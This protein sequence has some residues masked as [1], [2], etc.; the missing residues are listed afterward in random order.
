MR[1]CKS[2]SELKNK[3]RIEVSARKVIMNCTVLDGCAIL[4]LVSWP[5]SSDT[6][7]A[8]VM[9]YLNSFC[10]LIQ[11][12]LSTGD[13]YLVFDRYITFSTKGSYRKARGSEGCPVYQLSAS[14][15]LPPRKQVLNNAINKKQLIQ[16]IV[17]YFKAD[18]QIKRSCRA[19]K[20]S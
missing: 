17:D 5:T 15:P 1:I 6:I 16:I 19:A 18:D 10:V 11:K 9:G 4:W 20:A 14:S 2:K 7:P 12:Y 3:S 13:V 8:T